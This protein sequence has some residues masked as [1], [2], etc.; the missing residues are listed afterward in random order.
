MKLV[1]KMTL[2]IVAAMTLVVVVYATISIRVHRQ[3]LLDDIHRDNI[4]MAR[5]VADG[6]AT[7]YRY[8]GESAARAFV[9]VVDRHNL[10][11]TVDW[12]APRS[13]SARAGAEIA[14]VISHDE[15]GDSISTEAVATDE[16]GTVLG[17]A[18]VVDSLVDE[19][20]I[21]QA[22]VVRLIFTTVAM[23]L[24]GVGIAVALGRRYVAGPVR[25]LCERAA[26]IGRGE[27]PPPLTPSGRDEL[28]QLALAMNAMARELAVS[29][30]RVRDETD[31]RI[32]ALEQLRHAE[33]LATVGQLAAGI[34]HELG[35]PLNVVGA[36]A[37]MIE[38]GLRSGEE[39]QADLERYAAVIREQAARMAGIIRQLLGFA[40]RQVG[41]PAELDL[42]AVARGVT[43]L[44]R[45]LADRRGVALELDLPPTAP[46][47][48]D[49]AQ[50]EQVLTNIVVNAI[51]ACAEGGRVQVSVARSA[52]TP[53][54]DVAPAPHGF[55]CVR[56]CDDGAGISATNLPQVF[57]PFFTTKDVGQGTGLGLSVAYG[58]VRDHG[59]FIEA[60]SR[61]DEGSTFFA[62]L[63]AL[64]PGTA[65]A[66]DSPGPGSAT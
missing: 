19:E 45:P 26:Q 52:E 10:G 20:A 13:P 42:G 4:V 12:F 25:A 30:Q 54:P 50:L 59:G 33:R 61:E 34:A 48:G 15:D 27:L 5:I 57:E 21:L 14:Q 58:I 1:T 7:A 41:Q 24:L 39:A 22:R 23:A 66:A 47:R 55:V 9:D 8:G 16:D 43:E 44:V 46:I 37:T 6:V 11:M 2:A 51:Q 65:G 3:Q 63:P 32:A 36:R 38:Q 62:Y 64:G 60:R 53:P 17:R 40:R 18:S 28:A 56:V 35:T 31:A 29:A 49:R